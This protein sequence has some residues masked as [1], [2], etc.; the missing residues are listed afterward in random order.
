MQQLLGKQFLLNQIPDLDKRSIDDNTYQNLILNAVT[1]LIAL[2]EVTEDLQFKVLKGNNNF[3]NSL[4]LTEKQ[5]IG[6]YL[7]DV[8]D[9][10]TSEKWI[11]NNRQIIKEGQKKRFEDDYG[12]YGIFDVNIIPI[13]NKKGQF[14]Q[15]LVTALNI[16]ERKFAEEK[17]RQSQELFFAAFHANPN[18]M[19]LISYPEGLFIDVNEHFLKLH[20]YTRQELIGNPFL[21]LNLWQ[22]SQKGDELL[23]ILKE[24]GKIHNFEID[25]YTKEGNKLSG[26]L[27]LELIEINHQKCT[28]GCFTNLTERKKIEQEMIRL[29]RLG[30]IGELSASI[31]HEVRNP[32]TTVKGFLQLLS[33]EE[34]DNRKK[35]YYELMIEELDRANSIISEFL[36]LAKDKV[37]TMKPVCLNT[38]INALYPLL[39]TDALK[40]EKRIHLNKTDIPNLQLNEKEMRQLIINLVKNGLDAMEAGGTLTIG[41]YI[42]DDH[43]V[44]YIKDEGKGIQPEIFEKLGNPFLTT[45]E[46]GTGLGLAVCYSIASRHHA[47]I[48]VETGSKGT[49][50]FIR[51]DL[52]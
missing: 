44:L 30:L 37:V 36:S 15:L 10:K 38:I 2:Y 33:N 28:L 5:V 20:G 46:D 26:L 13:Q 40:Q 19:A 16:S 31:G 12:V 22:K 51:F 52:Y 7:Q 4:G 47:K 43:V 9:E 14:T 48:D 29:D 39:L 1:D 42:E 3:Y 17:L 34:S 24:G 50:F 6:K 27:S 11:R 21:E 23:K 18:S 41:T 45:K 35:D 8:L 49:T 25:F 32:M